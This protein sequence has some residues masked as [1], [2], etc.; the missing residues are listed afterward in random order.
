MSGWLQ[1]RKR[2]RLDITK[3]FSGRT[4]IGAGEFARIFYDPDLPP[5]IGDFD[6]EY[7]SDCNVLEEILSEMSKATGLPIALVRSYFSRKET[8][9]Q[10]GEHLLRAG[11]YS[12]GTK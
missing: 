8:F 10:F 3:A 2:M 4:G 9:A 1:N 6:G 5:L 12:R 11:A 7:I